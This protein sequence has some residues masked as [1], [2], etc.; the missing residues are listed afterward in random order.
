MSRNEIL[1]PS[2]LRMDGRRPF[3]FRSMEIHLS[4]HRS[5]S[6][7]S[8]HGGG[9]GVAS[10]SSTS[11]QADG[12]ARLVQG[13][14]DVTC[15]VSGP[16]ERIGGG[17]AAGGSGEGAKVDFEVANENASNVGQERRAQRSRNDR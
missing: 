16:R 11:N 9:G 12:S 13:L 14:N 15:I 2:L 10:S 8:N 1:T 5:S 7:N 4:P 6:N 17:G 3:E